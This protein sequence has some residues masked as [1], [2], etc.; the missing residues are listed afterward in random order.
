[1]RQQFGHGVVLLRRQACQY[2]LE[3][4]IRVMPVEPGRLDQAHDR[5]RTFAA[6]Q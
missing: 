3:I 1:M 6:A 2:I 4:G 5:R